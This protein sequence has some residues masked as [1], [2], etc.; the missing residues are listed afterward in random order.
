MSNPLFN[1]LGNAL[2]SNF[3]AGNMKNIAG[4]MQMFQQ[5]QQNFHGDPRQQVQQL[6]NSG[7]V[8]QEQ[9]NQAVQLA[10]QFQKM[11]NGR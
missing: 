3:G 11:I 10:N 6:L 4:L 9:Y 8:T 2:P 1:M 7:K 5:F